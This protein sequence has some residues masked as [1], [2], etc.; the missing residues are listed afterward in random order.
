MH[1]HTA[2]GR[3]SRDKVSG[4]QGLARL[5]VTG[6]GEEGRKGG[7]GWWTGL[8]FTTW[9]LSP[10]P[11]PHPSLLSHPSPSLPLSLSVRTGDPGDTEQRTELVQSSQQLSKLSATSL[12]SGDPPTAAPPPSPSP[13]TSIFLQAASY[14]LDVHALKVSGR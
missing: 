3:R 6:G 13:L 1:A 2:Q 8:S 12:H 14:L 5:L 4:L 7:G 11:T 10:L 9:S